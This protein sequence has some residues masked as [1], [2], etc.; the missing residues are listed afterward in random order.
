MPTPAWRSRKRLSKTSDTHGPQEP[1]PRSPEPGAPADALQRTARASKH[2]VKRAFRWHLALFSLLNVALTLVN[3]LTGPPWWALW[4]L[5]V[6]GLAM[7]VHY[8]LYKALTVDET[9]AEERVE[10]LNLKSYD[11]SHIEELKSR[12]GERSER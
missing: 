9:W 3:V 10:E 8:L 11:R 5:L 2:W 6:T 1:S 4:P 12:Y 7:G